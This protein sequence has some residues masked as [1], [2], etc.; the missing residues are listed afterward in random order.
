[1]PKILVENIKH[2]WKTLVIFVCVRG[3]FV[4]IK[5]SIFFFNKYLISWGK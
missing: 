4:A 1:M 3:I 5:D 2:H